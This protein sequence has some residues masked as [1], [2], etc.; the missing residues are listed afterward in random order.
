MWHAG[1]THPNMQRGVG[2]L[3]HPALRRAHAAP[4]GASGP[5]LCR[6]RQNILP[7]QSHLSSPWASGVAPWPPRCHLILALCCQPGQLPGLPALGTC[8]HHGV[9]GSGGSVVLGCRAVLGPVV[10]RDGAAGTGG[11]QWDA[12]G[13]WVKVVVFGC[14]DKYLG[15]GGPMR[16]QPMV[17]TGFAL[18]ATEWL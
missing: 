11:S 1:V 14:C 2:L 7:S 9:V 10:C 16:V 15:L 18:E 12:Q 13:R 5:S 6:A 4:Q 3:S 17:R 8:G